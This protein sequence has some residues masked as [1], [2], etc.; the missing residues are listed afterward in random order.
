MR[1]FG[2]SVCVWMNMVAW[3]I[4]AVAAEA[5]TFLMSASVSIAWFSHFEKGYYPA[6]ITATA[7]YRLFKRNTHVIGNLDSQLFV[8]A[9]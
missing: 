4:R 9:C 6:F 3:K 8:L 2:G 1:H 7:A 5:D